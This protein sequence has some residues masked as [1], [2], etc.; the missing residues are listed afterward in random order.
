MIK[1]LRRSVQF[2]AVSE[3][4][5]STVASSQEMMFL[6]LGKPLPFTSILQTA[7]SENG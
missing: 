2:S 3:S 4:Q 5:F 6:Q 1:P 7:P